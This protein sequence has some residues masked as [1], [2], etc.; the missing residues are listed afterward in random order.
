MGKLS[1]EDEMNKDKSS[2]KKKK[3]EYPKSTEQENTQDIEKEYI[4]STEHENQEE[5]ANIKVE[6]ESIIDTDANS[7]EVDIRTNEPIVVFFGPRSI[8]KTVALY[9]LVRY[10]RN[11][12]NLKVVADENFRKK[13]KH[14]E[15]ICKSINVDINSKKAPKG[16]SNIDFLLLKVSDSQTIC[17]LLEAPGEHYFDINEPDKNFPPYI[18]EIINK[19]ETKKIFIVFLEQAWETPK[20]RREY[21]RKI[22]NLTN[23]IDN[24]SHIIFLVNKADTFE[25]KQFIEKNRPKEKAFKKDAM[26]DYKNAFDSVRSRG[27][28]K[29]KYSFVVFS[30]GNFSEKTNK[31]VLI[32]D[33]SD[34]Y[35]AMLWGKIKNIIDSWF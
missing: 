18:Q 26:N 5:E 23:K 17:Q 13:D 31:G 8:G 10:L 30:S 11:K 21:V 34:Y 33:S 25:G 19:E 29:D 24:D 3:R 12:K 15:K 4:E 2:R 35:P 22:E 7:I 9:R 28:F 20:L 14:Y 16:T 32:T 27:W 1:L 6:E